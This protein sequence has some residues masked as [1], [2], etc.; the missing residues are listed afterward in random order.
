[1]RIFVVV[2]VL[3]ALV[4][5]TAADTGSDVQKKLRQQATKMLQQDEKIAQLE[6][7][8]EKLQVFPCN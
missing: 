4:P 2:V 6:A 7:I 1:M 3:L 8:I 5:L